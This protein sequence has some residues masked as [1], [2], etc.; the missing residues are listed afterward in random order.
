MNKN[1]SWKF[2]V[3]QL[4]GYLNFHLIGKHRWIPGFNIYS[5]NNSWVHSQ[6]FIDI[7][8]F[9]NIYIEFGKKLLNPRERIIKLCVNP[10]R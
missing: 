5:S 6:I 9:L 3:V 4:L 2:I 10:Y 7:R 8:K 1:S